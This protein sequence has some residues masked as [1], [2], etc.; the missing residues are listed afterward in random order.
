[1]VNAKI[2][3]TVII[4]LKIRS[5]IKLRVMIRIELT[6]IVSKFR[7]EDWRKKYYEK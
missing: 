2:M 1:M 5:L 3:A 7:I 4:Q 6:K